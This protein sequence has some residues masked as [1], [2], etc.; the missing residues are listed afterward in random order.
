MP[1]EKGSALI[2]VILITLVL[3]MVGLAAMLFMSV[4]DTISGNDRYQKE[5][6]YLAEVGLRAAE[7]KCASLPID[8][9]VIDA[10]LGYPDTYLTRP[11]NLDECRGY[12]HPGVALT[13]ITGAS[14]GNGYIG[15]TP[16][17]MQA[18]RYNPTGA[19]Q[20]RFGYYS[21]YVRNN[22][23]DT[24]GSATLDRD[25][26]VELVSIGTVVDAQG[27]IKYEKILAEE[28]NIAASASGEWSGVHGGILQKGMN[29]GNTNA[30]VYR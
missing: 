6:L 17:Y 12:Q 4:E 22:P 16:L 15:T 11:G 26:I 30:G 23:E 28:F 9:T 1:K 5:A 2:T 20:D 24:A 21:E 13:S 29:P 25:G 7:A 10:Q 8:E 14:A 19:T 18:V 27:N 3:T